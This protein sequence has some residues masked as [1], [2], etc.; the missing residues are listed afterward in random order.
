MMMGLLSD[1]V[2]SIEDGA[3]RED[4]TVQ[5]DPDVIEGLCRDDS[6]VLIDP[7]TMRAIAH[8]SMF[9][10]ERSG[11]A[12]CRSVPRHIRRKDAR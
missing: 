2:P 8:A 1:G 3:F 12:H 9:V 11:F 10:E 5:V 7:R 6:T 4:S